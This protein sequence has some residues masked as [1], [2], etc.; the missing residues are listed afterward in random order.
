M[1]MWCIVL[2]VILLLYMLHI[3]RYSTVMLFDVSSERG[4]IVKMCF[5][6]SLQLFVIATIQKMKIQQYIHE[7]NEHNTL[8]VCVCSHH[9]S[10]QPA[11]Q[12]NI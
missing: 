2:Y 10:K 7:Y 3:M 11:V 1:L 9:H 12:H 4:S 8:Y 5:N 6:D